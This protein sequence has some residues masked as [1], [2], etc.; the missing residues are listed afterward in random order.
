MQGCLYTS[1]YSEDV[2]LIKRIILSLFWRC[3]F[4]CEVQPS[5]PR[6]SVKFLTFFLIRIS[7]NSAGLLNGFSRLSLNTIMLDFKR[8]GNGGPFD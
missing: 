2:V 1:L 7:R 5:F 3:I 4:F 8:V 6:Y